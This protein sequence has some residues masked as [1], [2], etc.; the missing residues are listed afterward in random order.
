MKVNLDDAQET[1]DEL[2]AD[3]DALRVE[4]ELA[5]EENKNLKLQIRYLRADPTVNFR[6]A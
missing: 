3:N 1:I 2:V 4:L 6:V 5:L